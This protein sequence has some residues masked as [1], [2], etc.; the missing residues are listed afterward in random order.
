MIRIV[1]DLASDW[2]QLD[3]RIEAVTDEIETLAKSDDSCRRVMTCQVSADHLECDGC[4]DRQWRGIRERTGFFGV[5]RAC[6]RADVD[7][8]PNYPRA[9]LQT[10]QRLLA[11][12]LHASRPSHSDAAGELAKAQLESDGS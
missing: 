2:R 10:R 8:R 12:A 5:A 9:H 6:A 11:Y 4:G 3:E 7:R 1:A